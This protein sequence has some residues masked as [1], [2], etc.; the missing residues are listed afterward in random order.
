[1]RWF[2]DK[3]FGRRSVGAAPVG[4]CDCCSAVLHRVSGY[5]VVT[6]D[7]VLSEAYWRTNFAAA[8]E[9]AD[10]CNM[11]EMQLLQYFQYLVDHAAGQRSP[12]SICENCSEFFI[13]D[14]KIARS[15][16]INNSR[17]AG[18]G[19][20]DPSGCLLFAAAAWEQV[21]GRWP[22]IVT[23]ETVVDTCDLCRKRMYSGELFS[24][25]PHAQMEGFRTNGI[26]ENDPVSPPRPSKDGWV[27]C[28]PCTGR[29]LARCDRAGYRPG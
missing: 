8:K 26:I 22:A 29:L 1:V 2:K 13:F 17:P 20:V 4:V 15:H 11:G 3:L 25:I 7:V 19:K 12:W 5:F 9:F 6:R 10:R 24:T 28:Q 18:T 23:P 27:I 14:R 16:A 21:F